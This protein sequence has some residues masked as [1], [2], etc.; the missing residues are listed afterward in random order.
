MTTLT[1]TEISDYLQR[2]RAALA[3]LPAETREELLEDE[4]AH[5]AEV[6]A[7]G[8]ADL[9]G[10]LGPPERYAADLRA[11]AGLPPA[12][13]AVR[14][15]VV[16][17]EL[18]NNIKVYASRADRAAGR[19]VGYPRLVDLAHL[20]RPGWWVLR[21]YLLGLLVLLAARDEFFARLL[22][23]RLNPGESLVWLLVVGAAV[24][25]S[26]RVGRATPG[27]SRWRR[28]AVYA[29]GALIVLLALVNL[30]PRAFQYESGPSYYNPFGGI[31]DVYPYDQ[32][33]NPL[34]GVQF[35]DQ[36]GNPI[37]IGEYWRCHTEYPDPSIDR[38][39]YRYPLCPPSQ[40]R[41]GMEASAAPVTSEPGAGPS[42]QPE[43]SAPATTPTATPAA[44]P[45]R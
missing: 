16:V 10:R 32:N 43:A 31:T 3:D 2:V 42:A 37:Q 13:G 38:N 36:N 45:G 40:W 26:V 33:G 1:S 29:A 39:P 34:D 8:G 20:L 9:A 17:D 5:L 12:T 25:A 41:P 4:P 15:P 30:A 27:L 35:Y 14:A 28:W 19:L 24:V 23:F 11:A 22:P 44:S 18:L 7:E 21:G 6:L